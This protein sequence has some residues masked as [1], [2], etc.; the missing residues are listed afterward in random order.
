MVTWTSKRLIPIVSCYF[1]QTF[2]NKKCAFKTS[3]WWSNSCL[4]DRKGVWTPCLKFRFASSVDIWD[5]RKAIWYLS[6]NRIERC[7]TALLP[8]QWVTTQT[9]RMAEYLA[10]PCLSAFLLFK[11]LLWSKKTQVNWLRSIRLYTSLRLGKCGYTV[12]CHWVG[13]C[14]GS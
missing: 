1:K 2:C 10:L 9:H 7:R 13:E 3:V 12:S 6:P 5:I 11:Q 8:S 14:F 4:C